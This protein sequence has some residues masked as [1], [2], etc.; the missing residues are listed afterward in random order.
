VTLQIADNRHR[1]T[2]EFTVHK[3][4]SQCKIQCSSSRRFPSGPI[5]MMGAP[6]FL[7]S[8]TR[9]SQHGFGLYKI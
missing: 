7:H 6:S 5:Y 2:F 4:N 3:R 8:L 1:R 9:K